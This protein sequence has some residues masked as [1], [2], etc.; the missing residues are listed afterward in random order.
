MT[1]AQ[2]RVLVRLLD[3]EG[4]F[5]LKGSAAEVARPNYPY[6]KDEKS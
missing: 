3:Q 1:Q 2:K 6:C 4:V 5:R